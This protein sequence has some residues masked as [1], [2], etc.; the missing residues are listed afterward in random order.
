MLIGPGQLKQAPERL[1][2]SALD[3]I[4][5]APNGIDVDEISSLVS[6]ILRDDKKFNGKIVSVCNLYRY[7]GVHENFLAL[8]LLFDR[9]VRNWHYTIVGDGPYRSEL[10]QMVS[11]FGLSNYI[12]FMGRLPHGDAMRVIRSN[13]IFCLPSWM[14][15]YGQVYAEAAVCG[16]PAIGCLENGPEVIIRDQDTG[17]LIPP[18]DVNALANALEFLLTHPETAQDMGKRAAEHAKELSWQK[19]VQVYLKTFERLTSV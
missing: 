4:V 19:A 14:E 2:A 5:L 18:K 12:T 11:Q 17:F 8:K 9:G 7:K 1:P 10:E 3:K 16:V 13:D 6:G 15:A